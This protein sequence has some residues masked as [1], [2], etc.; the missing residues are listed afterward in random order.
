MLRGGLGGVDRVD[1]ITTD[2]LIWK[3]L[4][5]PVK[6]FIRELIIIFSR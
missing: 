4:I 6:R 1:N 5:Y 2:Y 3:T